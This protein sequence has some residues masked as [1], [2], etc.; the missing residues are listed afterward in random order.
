MR[1]VLEHFEKKTIDRLLPLVESRL[2]SGG[3][4]LV[5]VPNLANTLFGSYM[6]YGDYSHYTHFADKSLREAVQWNMK[7]CSVRC[8]N[9]FYRPFFSTNITLSLTFIVGLAVEL[10]SAF[11]TLPTYA[12]G[13]R[14][15]GPRLVAIITK[16]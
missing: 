1:H 6:A 16:K 10:F 12:Y 2:S 5:E 11:F 14:V 9:T 4:L 8:Y 13:N 15:F 7:S 3:R